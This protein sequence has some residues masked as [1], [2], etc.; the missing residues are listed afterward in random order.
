MHVVVSRGDGPPTAHA[1][2]S[3]RTER[4]GHLVVLTKCSLQVRPELIVCDPPDGEVRCPACYP[5][6]GRRR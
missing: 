3:F 6:Q 5:K 4:T 1:V 2:K